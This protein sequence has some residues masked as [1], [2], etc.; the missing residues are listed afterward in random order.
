MDVARVKVRQLLGMDL[1]RFGLVGGL[2]FVVNLALLTALYKGLGAPLFIAQ[3]ISAEIALFGNFFLHNYWTYKRHNVVK[4][5]RVLVVQFH[6]TSWIA[7][8]GSALL[9]SAGVHV[10]HLSYFVAL[11]IAAAAGMFWN[12]GWSKFVIWRHHHETPAQS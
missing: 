4:S 1:V 9:V 8:L 5:L 10:V 2:G 7:V 6:V 11:V 3:L 12:F